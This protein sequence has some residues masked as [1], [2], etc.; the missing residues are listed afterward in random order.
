MGFSTGIRSPVGF[1]EWQGSHQGIFFPIWT[2]FCGFD[3][4]VVL[5]QL[6]I[7][8]FEEGMWESGRLDN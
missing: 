6:D 2:T 7:F 3:K 1:A 4:F 8:I 5:Q